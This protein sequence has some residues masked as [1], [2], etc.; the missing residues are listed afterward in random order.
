MLQ[1][2]SP[3]ANLFKKSFSDDNVPTLVPTSISPVSNTAIDICL[4]GN[5]GSTKPIQ[6]HTIKQSE[7]KMTSSAPL[8]A[9]ALRIYHSVTLFDQIIDKA[10]GKFSKGQ[11]RMSK[12]GRPN[13][14]FS[15]IRE[16]S[17]DNILLPLFKSGFCSIYIK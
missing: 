17:F 8:E 5:T 12:F 6:H 2:I 14:K 1:N 7:T 10:L 9:E 3:S 13:W 15:F 11:K 4:H 16:P